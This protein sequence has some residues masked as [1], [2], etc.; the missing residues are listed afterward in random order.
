MTY[1][2]VLLEPIG[3]EY[4]EHEC[5]YSS[6]EQHTVF[7]SQARVAQELQE[8]LHQKHS[9]VLSGNIIIFNQ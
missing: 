1:N 4:A 9:S 8:S 5:N 7:S 2:A 6:T 3:E